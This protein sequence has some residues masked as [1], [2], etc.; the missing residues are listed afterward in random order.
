M[1][2]KATT[3]YNE[4]EEIA[5]D[6]PM[7]PEGKV[8]RRKSDGVIFPGAIHELGKLYFKNGKKLKT[9]YQEKPEDFELI[10]IKST[11]HDS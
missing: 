6:V 4:I 5:P 10:D 8:W 3:V 2:E 9:P 11:D 7:P 1:E